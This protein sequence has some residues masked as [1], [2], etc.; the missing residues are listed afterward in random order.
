MKDSDRGCKD[1]SM[2]TFYIEAVSIYNDDR[3]KKSEAETEPL[4]ET[5]SSCTGLLTFNMKD[6]HAI[7]VR[8][9]FFFSSLIALVEG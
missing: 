1:S 2:F 3:G 4:N 6:F 8:F 9:F 5:M 7:R